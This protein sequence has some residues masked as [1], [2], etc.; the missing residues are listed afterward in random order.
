MRDWLDDILNP[1]PEPEPKRTMI[2]PGYRPSPPSEWG[3]GRRPDPLTEPEAAA[4]LSAKEEET[5]TA[6]PERPAHLREG[7]ETPKPVKVPPKP[8]QPP[9]AVVAEKE[10]ETAETSETEGESEPEGEE[11]EA[12]EETKGRIR[13]AIEKARAVRNTTA[14]KIGK[15][16][17]PVGEKMEKARNEADP[18]Q[19]RKWGLLWSTVASWVVAPGTFGA[20]YDRGV[21]MFGSWTDSFP[22]AAYLDAGGQPQSWDFFEGPAYWVKETFGAAWEAGLTEDV[23]ASMGVGVVPV[24]ALT[25]FYT[26]DGGLW[27]LCVKAARWFA[28]LGVAY[29]VSFEWFPQWWEVYFSAL[30][31]TA[32]YGWMMAKRI[33]PGF[34]GFVLRIPMAALVSGMI[35]YSPGAVF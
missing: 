32:I 14:E 28:V 3:S 15:V 35:L 6:T 11:A 31:A 34:W 23:A 27:G 22:R 30:S 25:R 5:E 8:A 13:G 17:K 1:E 10:K 4:A 7:A 33:P 29:Y 26:D 9:V 19:A 12:E 2:S 16:K 24:I 21:D 18:K 20:L